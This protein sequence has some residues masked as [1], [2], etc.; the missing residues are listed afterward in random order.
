MVSKLKRFNQNNKKLKL[1]F[2]RLNNIYH[3]YIIHNNTKKI[4]KNI[5]KINLSIHFFY[6]INYNLIINFL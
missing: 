6:M 5:I 1:K 4:I 3:I 2:D